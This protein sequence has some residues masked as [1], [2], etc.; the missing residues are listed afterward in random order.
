MSLDESLFEP[1]VASPGALNYRCRAQIKC[2]KTVDGFVAGFYRSGTHFV[3]D[4]DQCPLLAPDLNRLL[5][6]IK[7]LFAQYQFAHRVPQLDLSVDD[8]ARLSLTVHFMDDDHSSLKVLLAP[9][10]EEL[11]CS[12]YVRKSR[13][14]GL[15]ALFPGARQKIK[16]LADDAMELQ[17]P[18]A[19]FVQVNLDQNRTLV[20]DVLEQIPA[21]TKVMDLYCGIGNF[22]LPISRIAST[23]V[24]VEDYA[25]AIESARAN[26]RD[27]GVE[28]AEFV[29]ADA[30][31]GLQS[32]WGEGFDLVLLDPPRAGAFDVV[33]QLGVLKPRKIVY[34]SC[35]PMTLSRDVQYLLAN[36]Y[37]AVLFRAYDM[38]PQT[39][40]IEG[41]VVLERLS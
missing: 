21:G 30:S 34:V 12:M 36:G 14:K 8:G 32:Q 17:Y 20:A 18:P 3:V 10:A 40:H 39:A 9:V 16:P 2:R 11:H 7:P 41:L 24:G 15:M 13:K 28:N 25:P 35:D 26:C 29:V 33:K 23:V 6:R 5:A 37:R 22:S 38:F 27:L 19:G 1:I 31:Y 4:I